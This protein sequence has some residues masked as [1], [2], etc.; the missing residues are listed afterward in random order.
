MSAQTSLCDDTPPADA[1][2]AFHLLAK[3]GESTCN[4]DCTYCFYLSQEALHPK[5][6]GRISEATRLRGCGD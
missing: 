4:V 3:P 2:P 1:P 6:K 5:E